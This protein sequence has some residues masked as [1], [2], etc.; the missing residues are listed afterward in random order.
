MAGHFLHFGCLG[1]AVSAGSS[2]PDRLIV[3]CIRSDSVYKIMEKAVNL[4]GTAYLSTPGEPDF[5]L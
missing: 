5:Q 2:K 1:S 3:P 4:R